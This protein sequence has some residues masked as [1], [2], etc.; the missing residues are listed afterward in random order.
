LKQTALAPWLSSP[1]VR[2]DTGLKASKRGEEGEWR[3]GISSAPVTLARLET[4]N[5]LFK[6]KKN[7]ILLL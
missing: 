2:A 4:F 3:Q 6:R 7:G 1:M 5:A